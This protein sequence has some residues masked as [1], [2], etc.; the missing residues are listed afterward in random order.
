MTKFLFVIIV[1]STH[2][3]NAIARQF[4]HLSLSLTLLLVCVLFR[5][6][7]PGMYVNG[8]RFMPTL[9]L[10]LTA[11]ALFVGVLRFHFGDNFRRPIYAINRLR[12]E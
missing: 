7:Y 6:S 8:S 9:T 2:V 3:K 1:Y 12:I 5:L 10:A 4:T 11:H